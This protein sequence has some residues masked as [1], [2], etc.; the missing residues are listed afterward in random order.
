MKM[1][2][3]RLLE[4]ISILRVSPQMNA[5]QYSKPLKEFLVKS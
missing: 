4:K 1:N 3:T 5:A 2:K